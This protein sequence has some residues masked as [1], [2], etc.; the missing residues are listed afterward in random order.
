[1]SMKGCWQ[2]RFRSL[3]I[4]RSWAPRVPAILCTQQQYKQASHSELLA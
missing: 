1:M 4:W 3:Q 2:M